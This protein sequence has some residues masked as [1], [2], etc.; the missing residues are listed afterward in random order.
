MRVGAFMVV[1]HV[2][3]GFGLIWMALQ[4]MSKNVELG[5]AFGGGAAYAHFGRKKGLD[6]G[7]KITAAL[8]VAFF[9]SSI[10]TAF[11]LK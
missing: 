4:Q 1:V 9:V 7:G 8:A 5:G 3:I 11:V 10:I 6:T 2:V